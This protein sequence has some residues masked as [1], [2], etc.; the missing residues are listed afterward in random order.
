MAQLT[1]A[2]MKSHKTSQQHIP[3]KDTTLYWIHVSQNKA[4]VKPESCIQRLARPVQPLAQQ[5]LSLSPFPSI[6]KEFLPWA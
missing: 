5:L 1:H 4:L 6:T 3:G 2:G